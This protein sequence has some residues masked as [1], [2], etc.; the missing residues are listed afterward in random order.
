MLEFSALMDEAK[1][2]LMLGKYN[3]NVVNLH[4]LCINS[5]DGLSLR[6]VREQKGNLEKLIS[7][8]KKTESV[9]FLKDF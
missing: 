4:G 2:M 3:D 5:L 8:I 1:T 7:I 9:L 6:N